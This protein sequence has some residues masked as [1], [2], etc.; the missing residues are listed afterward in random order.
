MS[1]TV[2]R[3]TSASISATDRAIRGEESAMGTPESR[4]R[5]LHQLFS[6]AEVA[7]DDSAE[8]WWRA[9]GSAIQMRARETLEDAIAAACF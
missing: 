9:R 6:R 7:G 2:D 8:P 5:G 3:R 4:Y 1:L